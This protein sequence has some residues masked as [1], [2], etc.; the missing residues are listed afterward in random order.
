MI[1][2]SLCMIVKNEEE[3]LPNILNCAKNI[4]D[5]IIV[6]DTGSEDR[7]KEIARLFQAQVFDYN[8]T[9]DFA[10]A[11]N[12]SFSKASKDYILWLDADDSLE[13][14]EQ[15]ELLKLK[16]VLD[17]KVDAVLMKYCIYTGVIGDSVTTFY[18]ERLVKRSKNFQWREPVHEYLDFNGEILTTDI[19]ICHTSKK[20]NSPRNLRIYEKMLSEGKKLN[21]RNHYYLARELFNCG[22]FDEAVTH[23]ENLL[24]LREDI[25]LYYLDACIRLAI[26]Y[27]ARNN[28]DKVLDSLH[29]SFKYDVPRAEVCCRLG[30]YYKSRED[31]KK[32]I[33]WFELATKLRKATENWGMVEYD[34]WDFVPYTELCSC[35]YRVGHP[36]AAL[37]YNSLALETKPKDKMSLS[38]KAL[39]EGVI[40]GLLT[41]PANTLQESPD[42]L[43]FK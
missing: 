26:C 11:R 30:Y 15:L 31:Y 37:Y 6:V 16:Q 7:T 12:F 41:L 1:T 43:Y 22:R 28:H 4:A 18:R 13:Y 42:L 10:A 34:C 32:A 2:I 36:E 5:E 20:S 25:T 29:R 39:L 27:A 40:T 17:P 9:D 8:W 19:C 38:N 23:F 24:A 33:F 14:L 21:V 35:Y 3:R